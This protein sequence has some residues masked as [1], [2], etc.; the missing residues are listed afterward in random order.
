[1]T[2]GDYTMVS[3]PKYQPS[4]N[5]R[6][7]ARQ[8]II[9]SMLEEAR[10]DVIKADIDLNF[11]KKIIQ[12][13]ELGSFVVNKLFTKEDIELN[14][15]TSQDKYNISLEKLNFLKDLRE[16]EKTAK[17]EKLI[18]NIGNSTPESISVTTEP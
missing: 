8:L 14:I 7:K 5:T 16:V 12:K 11:F 9:N 6:P 10:D 2:K 4:H 17:M 15:I 13:I 3:T 1:M 18:Q